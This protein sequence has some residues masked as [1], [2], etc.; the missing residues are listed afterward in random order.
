MKKIFILIL[1][2]LILI[3]GGVWIYLLLNGAPKSIEDI[4]DNIFGENTTVST[5]PTPVALE[6]QVDDYEEDRT[7]PI[8]AE[9]TKLTERPVAGAVIASTTDGL[10][11]RYMTKGTGHVY[12]I[13]LET[14]IET[15][16]SNQTIPYVVESYWSPS[17][18]RVVII[19]DID[20]TQGETFI[21]SLATG[22]SGSVEISLE[23][24]PR[25]E[26][27]AF[28]AQGQLFY[29]RKSTEGGLL[30]YSRNLQSGTASQIFSLPFGEGAVLWDIWE[31]KKHYVYT[32]PAIGF[33]GYLY[34]IS[35]NNLVKI[36]QSKNLVALR[37][38]ANT[39]LVTKNSG[40]DP[41]GLLLNIQTGI[42]NFVSLAT[43][44]EKCGASEIRM[45]CAASDS[46]KTTSFPVDWYRGTVSYADTLFTVGTSTGATSVALDLTQKS[47]EEID[48][49]DLRVSEYRA[50]FK[51]KKDDSLWLH[52]IP[53]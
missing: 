53:Q 26:N 1:V 24:T 19:T 39:L 28:G 34:G 44:R 12:D 4:R 10:V 14:G 49:L 51:N 7:I 38:D 50:I 22:D 18:N 25:L 21:G 23:E 35:G 17:G 42:G 46:A 11:V 41:Y 9:L 40:S 43:L 30:G 47:R 37:I 5:G 16:V 15:R 8:G 31:N 13:S 33:M 2:L 36:D 29:T 52:N 6:D 32:K 27:I 45:L 48:V 3:L 20:G